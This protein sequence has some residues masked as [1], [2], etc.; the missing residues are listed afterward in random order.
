MR[1]HAGIR[2]PDAAAT[3]DDKQIAVA[4]IELHADRRGVARRGFDRHDM[5]TGLT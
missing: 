2:A 5:R 4:I 1:E 3:D